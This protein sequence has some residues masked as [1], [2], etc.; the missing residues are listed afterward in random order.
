MP[1]FERFTPT[2]GLGN[3]DGYMKRLLG[4]SL[5]ESAHIHKL[6]N[7]RFTTPCRILP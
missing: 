2:R 4:T 5:G 6:G 1:R 7:L 3:Y